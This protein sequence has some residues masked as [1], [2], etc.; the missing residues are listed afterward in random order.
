MNKIKTTLVITTLT[1]TG[2]S[3]MN[4]ADVTGAWKT[5]FDTQ[6]GLQKYTFTF[7]QAG[8]TV[9]GQ[10]NSDI[11]GQ[12]REVELKDGK[13]KGDELTFF[14]TFEF[15]G[16]QIR[17]DYKG[18]VVGD[19]IKF[20]RN[21]ADFATEQLVAR[22]VKDAA[23]SD[24]P[25]T[26]APSPAAPGK[27]VRLYDGPAPGSEDW[28]QTE[29]ENRTNM[30][31]TRVVFNVT[32]PTLTVFQPEPAQANGT[33]VVICPGGAFFALS[34]DSEGFDVAR[35]LVAKGLTCF[36]LKYRLVECKTDDPT[37]EVMSRGRLDDIVA[38]I[39]KL[40]LADGL[41]AIGH[42]RKHARDYGVNPDRIG[43]VGFSAGGTVAASVAFNYTPETRPNFVAPIYLA[44]S[45][46]IKGNGVPTD[47]PP[48]FL[49]AATD[50]QL[51]LAPHSVNLYQDWTAAKK[52]AELHLFAKGGHGFGMRKQ[53]LPTDRWIERFADWLDLQGLLKK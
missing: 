37:R 30:W 52:P 31:N 6:I 22:R 12:K 42:V 46:T 41:A 33:A 19:E 1:L 35:W 20:T 25:A 9:T 39:V 23:P 29:Q 16:N 40:A 2:L 21:V 5:E 34:I 44:Y 14:E 47:A 51:G 3:T 8:G 45:W 27:V 15:D 38:P 36:V 43:I 49:L 48:M 11:A 24:A 28:K 13:V 26:A 10:A 32:N 50:D 53:N 17:I 4:A 7:K 18:K